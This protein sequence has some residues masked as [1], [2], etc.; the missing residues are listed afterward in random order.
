MFPVVLVLSFTYEE[1]LVTQSAEFENL[2][3]RETPVIC[4]SH[5]PLKYIIG[6]WKKRT[7]IPMVH[8]NTKS[9]IGKTS[10]YPIFRS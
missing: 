2:E 8:L 6:K 7:D 5:F 1:S 10:R 3:K 4:L 9:E